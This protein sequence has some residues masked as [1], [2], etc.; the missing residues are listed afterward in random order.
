M[1]ALAAPIPMAK[2]KSFATLN[3]PFSLSISVSGCG[4][5]HYKA[6]FP[7]FVVPL[8]LQTLQRR[9][10]RLSYLPLQQPGPRR[11]DRTDT[12]LGD[13]LSIALT[14]RKEKL[15]AH[16]MSCTCTCMCCTTLLSNFPPN[17]ICSR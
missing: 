4:Q 3:L 5:I 9:K 14:H 10:Q 6:S 17:L 16:Y 8:P 2:L 7:I 12:L 11:P 15:E 13:H 1:R